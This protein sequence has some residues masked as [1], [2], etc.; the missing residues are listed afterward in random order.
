MKD[1]TKL[2]HERALITCVIMLF[3]CIILKLFGFQW[4]N[5]DTDIPILKE[6]DKIVMSNYW[7]CLLYSS[8][9]LSINLFFIISITLKLD[10]KRGIKYTIKLL[11]F[12]IF[13][14]LLKTEVMLVSN[15]SFMLD[16]AYLL[17]SCKLID[18]KVKIKRIVAVI[19]L[20]ILYQWVSLFIKSLNTQIGQYGYLTSVLFM[21]DY[22]IMLLITYLYIMRGG[23]IC[24]IFQVSFSFLANRLW[25][26]RTTNSKQSLQNKE[27]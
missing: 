2:L 25:R 15:S 21:I 10:I 9:L 20:N 1:K 18:P 7:L 6:I 26:R 23:K 14:I 19:F 16:I 4:F 8:V 3:L 24:Q 27:R 5:L 12:T 22:Y 13:I 11:P 17:F